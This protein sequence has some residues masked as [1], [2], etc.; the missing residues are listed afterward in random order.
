VAKPQ[1]QHS[2]SQR[3]ARRFN[4]SEAGG[5]GGQ[6]PRRG[7]MVGQSADWSIPGWS[8]RSIPGAMAFILNALSFLTSAVLIR[9]NAICRAARWAAAPAPPARSGRL[10]AG[11]GGDPIYPQS[12][13]TVPPCS[14]RQENSWWARA[15]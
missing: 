11:H 9:G 8:S 7:D 12:S 5:S 1:W 2:L 4:I 3:A 14:R 13:S 10:L 15:G 6:H